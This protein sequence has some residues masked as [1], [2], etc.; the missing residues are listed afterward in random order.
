MGGGEGERVGRGVPFGARG[1]CG[2][3]GGG[4]GWGGEF[5]LVLGVSVGGRRGGEGVEGRGRGW[6][7]EFPL[8]L[9]V[10]VGGRRGGEGGEGGRPER[11]KSEGREVMR[12]GR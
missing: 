12:E 10:S 3:R 7:G 6:G 1:E 8:V 11:E 4:K 2:G 5:P 9:G